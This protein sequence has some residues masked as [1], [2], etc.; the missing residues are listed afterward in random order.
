MLVVAAF[1]SEGRDG[2]DGE[3]AGS[4]D[5][6]GGTTTVVCVVGGGGGGAEGELVFISTCIIVLFLVSDRVAVGVLV[7]PAV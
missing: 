4:E 3:E 2:T 7:F 5:V 1:A 6:D